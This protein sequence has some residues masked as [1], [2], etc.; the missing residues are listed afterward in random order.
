MGPR[1]KSVSTRHAVAS[2]ND[3]RKSHNAN[4]GHISTVSG[5]SKGGRSRVT[6]STHPES[7]SSEE[8]ARLNSSDEKEAAATTLEMDL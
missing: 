3:L 4:R 1:S 5:Y 2:G 6:N 8:V 7:L